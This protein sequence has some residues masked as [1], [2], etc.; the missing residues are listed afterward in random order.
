MKIN[1]VRKFIASFAT[2]FGVF[3][4]F[5]YAQAGGPNWDI[6][7]ICTDKQTQLP[8]E[9]VFQQV[10]GD[11]SP[12]FG[13]MMF[14][15][16]DSDLKEEKSSDRIERFTKKFVAYKEICIED[17]STLPSYT[18][19]LLDSW[20]KSTFSGSFSEFGGFAIVPSRENITSNLFDSVKTKKITKLGENWELYYT[21]VKTSFGWKLGWYKFKNFLSSK[22]QL[23]IPNLE[24]SSS[25][26]STVRNFKGGNVLKKS[27]S[28]EKMEME[29]KEK[30]TNS[31]QKSNPAGQKPTLTFRV[32]KGYANYGTSDN[33]NIAKEGMVLPAGDTD[34]FRYAITVDVSPY[35]L[36]NGPFRGLDI[37]STKSK[38]VSNILGTEYTWL[39][40]FGGQKEL[41]LVLPLRGYYIYVSAEP[42]VDMNIYNDFVSSLKIK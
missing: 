35:D 6:T 26:I 27:V 2:L 19:T 30:T 32:P 12:A 28:A 18:P 25:E 13:P 38:K 22:K 15:M 7:L 33:V 20:V 16:V 9:F 11:A 17:L 10:R 42:G 8:V 37:V 24:I 41:L 21:P 5:S 3:G 31:E 40:D 14:K 1:F 36:N 23:S 34:A 39:N 4:L 29:K